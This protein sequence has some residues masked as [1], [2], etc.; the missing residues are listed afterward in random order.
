MASLMYSSFLCLNL[1]SQSWRWYL[2]RDSTIEPL[3][4]LR[5]T[6]A[7]TANARAAKQSCIV[8]NEDDLTKLIFVTN[9]APKEQ[10][11]MNHQNDL[12]SQQS[13]LSVLALLACL[14]MAPTNI[15]IVIAQDLPPV[16]VQPAA[17]GETT[18]TAW[19]NLEG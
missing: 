19:Q 12:R 1:G 18:Y 4:Q 17:P 8:S 2:D 11:N 15:N 6:T 10:S 16:V 13:A 5:R 7:C 14:A 9:A 3:D